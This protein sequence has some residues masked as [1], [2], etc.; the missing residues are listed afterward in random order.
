MHLKI[1]DQLAENIIGVTVDKKSIINWIE[2]DTDEGW[3]KALVPKPEPV[4]FIK[5][6]NPLLDP[7]DITSE[8]EWEEKVFTGTVAVYTFK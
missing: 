6:V 7:A 3:V 1:E 4:Q 5:N 2:F 8:P